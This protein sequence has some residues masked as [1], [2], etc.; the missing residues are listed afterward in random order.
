MYFSSIN[1]DGT[2][3]FMLIFH[4]VFFFLHGIIGKTHHEHI[5]NEIDKKIEL[6]FNLGDRETK[7]KCSICEQQMKHTNVYLRMQ[8]GAV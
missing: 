3:G 5:T 7:K 2:F 1:G 6:K 4:L 8:C